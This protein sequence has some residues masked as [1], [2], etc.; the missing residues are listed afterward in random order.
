MDEDPAIQA[1]EEMLAQIEEEEDSCS[2]ID[3]FLV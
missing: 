1:A 3:I 2:S